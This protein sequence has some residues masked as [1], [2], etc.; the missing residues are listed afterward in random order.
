MNLFFC[1]F[2][3]F[4]FPDLYNLTHSIFIE[5]IWIT[6]LE[7]PK[8]SKIIFLVNILIKSMMSQLAFLSSCL[9]LVVRTMQINNISM[10]NESHWVQKIWNL[11]WAG[12]TLVWEKREREAVYAALSFS[13]RSHKTKL[14]VYDLISFLLSSKIDLYLS[15]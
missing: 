3:S 11:S 6:F 13:L 10:Y 5:S 9:T 12:K 14:S 7:Q 15:D 4:C 1:S 8:C 2:F